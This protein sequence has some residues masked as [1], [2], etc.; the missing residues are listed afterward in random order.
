MRDTT[1][2]LHCTDALI[3][4]FPLHNIVYILLNMAEAGL[5]LMLSRNTRVALRSALKQMVH[6]DGDGNQMG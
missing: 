3:Y 2:H 5:L 1:S 4:L 6:L